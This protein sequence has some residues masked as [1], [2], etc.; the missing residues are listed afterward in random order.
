MPIF[1]AIKQLKQQQY[2]SFLQIYIDIH[3][4]STM[5]KI[6]QIELNIR[7]PLVHHVWLQHRTFTTSAALSLTFL[8]NYYIY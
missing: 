7:S 8:I 4:A 1:N 5:V 6:N 3:A 2:G